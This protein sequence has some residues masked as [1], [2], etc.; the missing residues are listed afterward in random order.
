MMF[1]AS[2]NAVSNF[3]RTQLVKD[4]L[5]A[6]TKSDYRGITTESL[7]AAGFS[8]RGVQISFRFGPYAEALRLHRHRARTRARRRS[9]GI[10]RLRA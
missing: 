3:R 8:N 9:S 6:E 5:E 1:C 7:P 2:E 4:A 10:R